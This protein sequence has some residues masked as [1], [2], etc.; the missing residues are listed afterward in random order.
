[1]LVAMLLNFHLFFL[2][3]SLSLL[4]TTICFPKTYLRLIY[5]SLQVISPSWLYYTWLQK[6]FQGLQDYCISRVYI[7]P[8]LQ[9]CLTPSWR[10][11]ENDISFPHIRSIQ[12]L[13]NRQ[14]WS[15]QTFTHSPIFRWSWWRLVCWWLDINSKELSLLRREIH[16]LISI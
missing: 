2:Y 16:I 9:S 3:P 11:W 7:T 10:K 15:V 8:T 13:I 6:I 1:M 4:V 5:S 14:G 12:C